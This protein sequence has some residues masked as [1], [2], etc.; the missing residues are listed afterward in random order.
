M[1]L[2]DAS[3]RRP[4]GYADLTE[5]LSLETIPNWH[6]SWVESVGVQRTETDGV[7]TETLCTVSPKCTEQNVQRQHNYNNVKVKIQLKA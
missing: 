6:A 4:A 2:F 1:A 5:R 7:R 3:T